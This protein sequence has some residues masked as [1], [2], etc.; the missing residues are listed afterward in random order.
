[1][2]TERISRNDDI[3]TIKLVLT[4]WF[5]LTDEVIFNSSRIFTEAIVF[6]D[7]FKLHY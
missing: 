7:F 6:G 5:L 1:M 2:S 3:I 4:K